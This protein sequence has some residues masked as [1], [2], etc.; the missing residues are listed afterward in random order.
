MKRYAVCGNPIK[1]SLSPIIF[2]QIFNNNNF[3][4][5]YN[6]ILVDKPD[7]AIYLFNALGLAGMNVTA[8]FKSSI[9]KFCTSCTNDAEEI[10][11]VNTIVRHSDKLLGFNTDWESVL[12]SLRQC[13]VSLENQNL[14]QKKILVIGAG[15][16]A[17]AAIYGIKTF[18]PNADITILN[19]SEG[20]ANQLALKFNIP[21]F[22]AENPLTKQIA[23]YDVVVITVTNTEYL[24]KVSFPKNVILF[25]ADYTNRKYLDTIKSKF[26]N[27]ILGETW[28]VNQAFPA[29]EYFS[30]N[31]EI[32]KKHNLNSE[33]ITQYLDSFGTAN[34]YLTGFSG[35]GKSY[36]GKEL[37]GKLQRDFIDIDEIVENK[38]Q[39]TINQIF[40]TEGEEAFRQ[41][42]A[43][44]LNKI[45]NEERLIVSLGGGTITNKQ[46]QKIIK[47]HSGF[48]VYLFSDLKTSLDRID[49]N[50]RPMLQ[51]KSDQEIE[52]LYSYRQEQYFINS[53]LIALH[54]FSNEKTITEMLANELGVQ[55]K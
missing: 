40:E 44:V 31:D 12:Y 33:L 54:N 52:R 22:V 20:R 37:A 18:Y 15:S 7:E 16:A 5:S 1:H 51:N 49:I 4:A 23:N 14:E 11:A 38:L 47:A 2:Q 36:I 43:D 26:K 13:L 8:P 50:S 6:R 34:I 17:A 53:N 42:E 27:T 39:K 46:N 32:C 28:L 25:F 24:S 55:Y 21:Y 41:Y 19:K 9:R 45:R 35:A 48:V 29:F 30:G 3:E 10:E